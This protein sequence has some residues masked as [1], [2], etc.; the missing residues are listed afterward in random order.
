LQI[1]T[2]RAQLYTEARATVICI[3]GLSVIITLIAK[4]FLSPYSTV[5]GQIVLAVVMALVVASAAILVQ[6]GRPR[7]ERR[8]LGADLDDGS[9]GGR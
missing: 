6:A 4:D 3:G 1:E 9:E 8:L 5:A 2:E 7:P